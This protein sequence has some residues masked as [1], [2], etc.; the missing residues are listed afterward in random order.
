[1]SLRKK[2]HVIIYILCM[3]CIVWS[4]VWKLPEF[5]AMAGDLHS[6]IL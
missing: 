4:I 1:M 2:M 6:Y 5:P 3:Y